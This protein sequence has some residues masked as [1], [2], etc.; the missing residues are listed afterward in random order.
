MEG[1]RNLVV[2]DLSR[3]WIEYD[4]NTDTLYITSGR[5][6]PTRACL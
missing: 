4:R 6:S 3:L 2:E 1:L 5:G